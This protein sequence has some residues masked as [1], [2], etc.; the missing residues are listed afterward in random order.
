MFSEVIGILLATMMTV[1]Y[2]YPD[3]LMNVLLSMVK[4]KKTGAFDF[5]VEGVKIVKSSFTT[6]ITID[7][8]Y[9][10]N[11]PLCYSSPYFVR[12]SGLMVE[13]DTQSVFHAVVIDRSSSSV[14]K[15]H[16]VEIDQ[17]D[18][19]IVNKGDDDDI[20]ATT[21]N[22][23]ACMGSKTDEEATQLLSVIQQSINKV[24]DQIS[25][26]L[27]PSL[28]SERRD[29]GRDEVDNQ[30]IPYKL[31]LSRFALKRLT[32]HAPALIG[33]TSPPMLIT[34]I[35]LTE[36]LLSITDAASM[37]DLLFHIV[38]QIIQRI[39][40]KYPMLTMRLMIRGVL[41]LGRGD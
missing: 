3:L 32:V 40:A 39:V 41:N 7:L 16:N 15:I 27:A 8:L 9:W 11:P 20:G 10:K 6:V 22:L 33:P 13:L 30:Y 19:Y 2:F 37:N 35:E 25:T 36:E 4:D 18:V 26:N 14:V 1:G 34:T 28:S 12:M 38:G 29:A 21:L 5:M 17:M 24:L 23:W 31:Q